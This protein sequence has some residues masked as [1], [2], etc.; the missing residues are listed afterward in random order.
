MRWVLRLIYL[1]LLAALLVP[2]GF[3]VAALSREK[4]ETEALM[5]AEGRLVETRF[6]RVYVEEQGPADGIPIL[7]AHGTGAWSGLWRETMAALAD[8]GYRAIAFDMPPFGFSDRDALARY[9]RV[10][11]AARIVELVTALEIR[12]ILVGHSFGAGPAA[13]AALRAPDRFAGLVLVDAALGVGTADPDARLPLILRPD[14]L[15]P[16]VVAT[17]A[18]NPLLTERLLRSFLYRKDRAAP[19]VELL[20]LPLTRRGTTAAISDW[21]PSLLLPPNGALSILPDAVARISLPTAIIWG[22]RD[23]VTPLAQGEE[24]ARL[25]PGATLTIL[26]DIGHV[27]HV[28][29]PA[30][31]QEALV[32][33]LAGLEIPG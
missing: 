14:W 3:Y 15:R 8:Q 24:L 33:A 12:P 32:A 21:L 18:T 28:E 4:A 23:S 26:T 30:A 16:V 20:R 2:A 10:T 13:E 11:Q 25:I 9:D 1:V 19:Y 22:D 5:P 31:F 7:L 27:P 17:T 6:G 29:D